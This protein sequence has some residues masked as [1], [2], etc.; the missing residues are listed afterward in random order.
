MWDTF[1]SRRSSSIGYPYT[2]VYLVFVVVILSYMRYVM[3]SILAQDYPLFKLTR[4]RLFAYY[5]T[6]TDVGDASF[7]SFL[8]VSFLFASF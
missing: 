1:F 7:V 5:I 2:N 4:F 3:E 8:F 6:L